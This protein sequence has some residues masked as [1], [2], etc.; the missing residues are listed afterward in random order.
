MIRVL[1]GYARAAGRDPVLQNRDDILDGLPRIRIIAAPLQFDIPARAAGPRL[2]RYLVIVFLSLRV[3]PDM[4][5]NHL[6]AAHKVIPAPFRHFEPEPHNRRRVRPAVYVPALHGYCP[7]AP[8]DYIRVLRDYRYVIHHRNR[9]AVFI[10]VPV[11]DIVRPVDQQGLVIVNNFSE[12]AGHLS[13]VGVILSVLDVHVSALCRVRKLYRRARVAEHGDS[14]AVYSISRS[15]CAFIKVFSLMAVDRVVL[16]GE[17][18]IPAAFFVPEPLILVYLA[19]I[20][21]L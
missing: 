13:L 2:Q 9:L 1:H 5:G 14:N 17:G 4:R 20:D 8:L 10:I 15:L 11:I 16:P 3:P 19:E 21:V 6:R 12:N 18:I 7:A